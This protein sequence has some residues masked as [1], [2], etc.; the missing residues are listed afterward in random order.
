MTGTTFEAAL[1]PDE[2]KRSLC[3]EL[4]EKF[5]GNVKRINDN[6][7]E[8]VHGCLVSPQ[9]HSNQDKE[10]T[11]SLNYKKLTYKCLGCGC[12]GG[13]LW[14]IATCEGTTSHAAKVWLEKTAGLGQNVMELDAFLRFLNS[15]YKRRTPQPLPTYSERL[16]KPFYHPYL[17]DRGISRT[18]QERFKVGWDEHEDRIVLPHFWKGKLVGWQ[19]RRLPVEYWSKQAEREGPKYLSSP[20]F[21]KDLTIFNDAPTTSTVVVESMMSVVRHGHA[22]DMTA[23]FGA[24]ITETQTRCLTRFDRVT[25]WLDN[26]AAGWSAIEGHPARKRTHSSP[27]REE[28]IGLAAALS[29]STSVWVVDSP[30]SQDAGDLPTEEA[31]RLA[32]GCAVPWTVWKRPGVLYCF[33]CKREAHKG[34]CTP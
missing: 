17:E 6:T 34:P 25:L 30:W 19:T 24:S 3:L 7:G 22:L 4:L 16:L 23:T 26:D 18:N 1:L 27:A 33:E 12:A 31:Q 13:L 29:R 10:P 2:A 32:K 5:Q 9:L 21:P 28:K 15:L 8:L 14:F 20:D 11:A